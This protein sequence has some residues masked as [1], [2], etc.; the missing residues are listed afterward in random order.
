MTLSF[1]PCYRVTLKLI[2]KHWLTFETPGFDVE[3]KFSVKPPF[4]SEQSLIHRIDTL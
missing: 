3:I 1:T 4:Y 2:D